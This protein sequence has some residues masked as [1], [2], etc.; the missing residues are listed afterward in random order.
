MTLSR[1]GFLAGLL[2]AAAC[3]SREGDSP[4][5]WSTGSTG[6][7]IT[8][9]SVPGIDTAGNPF[10]LGVASGDP[11]ERSVVLWTRLA[12]DPMVAGAGLPAGDVDVAWEVARDEEF[13]HIVVA[14]IAPAA[15]ALAHSVHV[16]ADGLD[17]ASTYWYRFRLGELTSVVGRTRTAPPPGEAAAVRLAVA[18][19]QRY[20][21]GFFA[22]HRDVANAD[23]DLVAFLGDYVYEADTAPDAVRPV[24]GP[25]GVAADLDAY[26]RRYAAARLD[27][28]LAAAHA[29]H[30]WAI[31]WDDHEVR[32][33]HAGGVDS[34]GALARRAAAYQAWYEHQPVR[35]PPPDGPSWPVHRSVRWGST[36]ELLLL[37]TRQHR[38]VQGCGGGIGGASCAELADGARTLLGTEQEAWLLDRLAGAA[39]TWTALA[40]QV[41]FSPMEVLGQVNLDA[42]DGYPAQRQ[43]V[44][45][46]LAAGPV[47]NAVV[48]TG[49]I[50]AELVA[51]VPD[52]AT[53]LVTSSVS[54][55]FASN[56]SGVFGLLPAVAENV[57]HAS[58]D[59]RGW[60]RCEI[61]ESGW[62]AT[63]RRVVDVANPASPVVDGPTFEIRNGRPGA[64]LS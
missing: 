11:D 2:A 6:P 10:T 54:S 42:W 58:S 49:D 22:A 59:H 40:Q 56:F 63:Y 31:T 41:V 28:D 12:P 48:L 37:D 21:H 15:T 20:D 24:P 52:V 53:E 16:V 57:R 1:R 13:E 25:V 60:L 26:R 27:P 64:R 61:D 8:P 9:P 44:V 45:D 34:G 36:L 29:R 30:P 17:A 33:D 7:R 62:R 23:V 14:G 47:R 43:R 19:C 5:A 32:N 51:G 3:S 50:H 46:A 39:T 55:R 18:S 4:L 35:L 38:S